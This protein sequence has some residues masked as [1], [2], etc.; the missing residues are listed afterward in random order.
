MKRLPCTLFL[1]LLTCIPLSAQQDE[2]A[3]LF[4]VMD[5]W[6]D[7]QQAYEALPGL[8]VAI[9][10]DQ[11]VV[12]SRA[13]GLSNPAEEKVATTETIYSICSISKLF[14]AVAI[15]KLYDEGKLRLDDEVG[16]LLPFYDLAQQFED[17][18]PVT[19]RS[20]MT[21][22]SGLPREAVNPY[23]TGPGF[24]FPTQSEVHAGLEEQETLYPASTYFQYSNLGLTLLG[25]IVEQVSG[26]PYDEYIHAHILEPLKMADTRTTMPED[27]HGQSLSVGHS[28]ITRNGSRQ[29]VPLFQAK[30]VRAAAGFSST[31]MD[32]AE[33]AKWQFRLLENGGKE[34]LKVATLK[35][36]HRVHWTNPDWSTT[37]G[38]GFSVYE[39]DGATIVGHGGSCPGYRS[40]ISLNPREKTAVIVMINASGTDPGKYAKGL[41]GLMRAYGN[42]DS[43]AG[44]DLEEYRMTCS[45]QPWWSEEYVFPWKGKLGMLGL[46]SNNPSRFSLYKHIEGDLFKRLRKDD[47]LGEAVRFHRDAQGK[48]QYYEQHGNL[49]H[50]INK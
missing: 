22:S 15:M 36:M 47:E 5:A 25:E 30:G 11:E 44:P 18:G 21:H 50:R 7:A 2:D 10:R 46:P 17:S 35:N 32:L 43:T 45:P 4:R 38:L 34:I 29:P 20:L 24:P 41:A 13:F 39:S 16:D 40:T 48:I 33:F 14:T 9:V 3:E 49:T 8:S 23:W 26:V 1:A 12:Y 37:W 31:V 27:L 19:I 42:A 28:S 6:L